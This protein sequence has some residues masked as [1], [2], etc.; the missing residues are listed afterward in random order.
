MIIERAKPRTAQTLTDIAF[1]A[2][3]HWNYPQNWI[4]SWRDAMTVQPEFIASHETYAVLVDGRI[5]GF[6]ALVEK[7]DKLDLVYVGIA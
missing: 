1:A 6:Y 3:R 5:V 7:G 4:D 2:K